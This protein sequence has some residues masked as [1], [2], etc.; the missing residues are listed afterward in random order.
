MRSVVLIGVNEL[1]AQSRVSVYIIY[2]NIDFFT[3]VIKIYDHCM[4]ACLVHSLVY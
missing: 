1:G 4:H 2:A 3:P